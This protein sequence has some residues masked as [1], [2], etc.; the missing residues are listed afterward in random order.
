M[1]EEM[2]DRII[3]QGFLTFGDLRDT[4]SRNQLKLPD[5]QDP[6]DFI[7]GDPLLRLDRRLG[8]LLDGVY[9]PSEIYMRWLERLTALNFGTRIGRTITRW[10][11]VPFGGA[12]LLLKGVEIVLQHA[13]PHHT[14]QVVAETITVQGTAAGAG[15]PEGWGAGAAPVAEPTSLAKAAAGA[16]VVE[17]AFQIP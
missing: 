10:V 12:A 5:L 9:R 11:T 7:R 6:Q 17:P 3:S 1:V 15:P 4:I 14:A 13:L 8:S 16:P 2:L